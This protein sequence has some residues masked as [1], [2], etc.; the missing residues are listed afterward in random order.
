VGISFPV[1]LGIFG[2]YAFLLFVGFT[3]AVWIII[4]KFLPETK[5][6]NIDEI[7]DYFCPK[8]NKKNLSVD[9]EGSLMLEPI[10]PV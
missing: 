1:L 8:Q 5:G 9:I 4:Y 10:D 7:G 6:K 2:H 3:F